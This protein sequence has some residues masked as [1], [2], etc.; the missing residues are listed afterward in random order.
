[1]NLEHI[2][3]FGL[4]LPTTFPD[5]RRYGYPGSP[6]ALH[7]DGDK[8]YVASHNVW[9][10]VGLIQIPT[11]NSPRAEHVIEPKPPESDQAHQ[12]RL[13]KGLDT[14]AGFTV[15][16]LRLHYTFYTYYSVQPLSQI[17]HPTFGSTDLSLNDPSQYL[18]A[19]VPYHQKSTA[20][21]MCSHDG[22][23]Y[24]GRGNGAGNFNAPRGPA[25]YR[26]DPA[27][28]QDSV[29]QIYRLDHSPQNTEK[30]PDWHPT[31]QWNGLAFIGDTPVFSG[32]KGFGRH[33]YGEPT[34]TWEDGTT[35]KDPI[36]T[37]KGFHSEDYLPCIQVGLDQNPR[38][39]ITLQG[40][41]PYATALGCAYDPITR[42][43][44]VLEDGHEVG[45]PREPL[46][47]V[48]AVTHTQPPATEPLPPPPH[49]TTIIVTTDTADMI[50]RSPPPKVHI[51]A[52]AYLLKLATE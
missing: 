14:L 34:T 39:F 7:P 44:F 43:L 25:L 9:D 21:Y 51:D 5:T 16:Q 27:D 42:R 24:C 29:E 26:F 17:D 3:S 46:I 4:P 50:F 28:P 22:W 20:G 52:A 45:S 6:I 15:H 1:M 41:R 13:S 12:Y 35:S 33:W 8:L 18:Q 23:I 48:Y 10:Q 49:E 31:D 32:V 37:A 40:F 19:L 47:H 30:A 11:E 38:N 2:S 36:R